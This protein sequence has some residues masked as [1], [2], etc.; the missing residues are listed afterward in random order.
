MK[1]REVLNRL[2]HAAK[3]APAV[4]PEPMPEHL[5]TRILARCAAQTGIVDVL[6][7]MQ[8][9][10]RL[11]LGVGVAIMLVCSV[12]SYHAVLDQPDDDIEL[13]TANAQLDPQL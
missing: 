9:V 6:P 4:E 1:M 8:R 7:A 3:A 12:W 2:L 13:A 5:K 11:G 10:F